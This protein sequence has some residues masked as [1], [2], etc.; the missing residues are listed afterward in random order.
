MAG[1]E[2]FSILIGILSTLGMAFCVTGL[3]VVLCTMGAFACAFACDLVCTM[4]VSFT[5]FGNFLSMF[6]LY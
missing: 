6:P 2:S 4:Y 1:F 3:P 5:M